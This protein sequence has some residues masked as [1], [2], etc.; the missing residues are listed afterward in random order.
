MSRVPTL[1]AV[2]SLYADKEIEVKAI[3]DCGDWII[4]I[5]RQKAPFIKV[6]IP[7]VAMDALVAGWADFK[8]YV[9]ARD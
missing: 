6:E 2:K 5:D 8:E 9:D 1:F 4:A 7:L 3:F